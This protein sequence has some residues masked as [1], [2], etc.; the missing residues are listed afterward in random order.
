VTEVVQL[1]VSGLENGISYSLVGLALVLIYQTSAA[2]NFAQGTMAAISGFVA[3]EIVVAN[4]LPWVLGALAGIL[5]GGLLGGV[6][7]R[8]A[9]RPLLGAPLL[10]LVIATI[11]VDS[12]LSNLTQLIR[13]PDTRALPS[14]LGG[15]DLHLGDV[16]INRT[17]LV[18]AASTIAIL[19]GVGWLLRHTRLGLAMR[20]FADDQFASELQG[21]SPQH[22][23]RMVWIISAAIGGIT[24]V[25][26]G[27]LLFIQ[28][29]YMTPIFIK[30]FTAAVLGGF[31][32][33]GGAVAGGLL[34]GVLEA[35]SVKYVSSTFAPILPLLIILVA[36]LARPSGVFNR[37]SV[38]QRV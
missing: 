28:V 9:I 15:S 5:V 30:G 32:S 23:S 38:V 11:A 14:P 27:P 18:I 10:S 20:A 16:A 29:G 2:L 1:V 33:N 25:L 4:H 21:I 22:V 19:L 24:G 36:L 34:L 8:V 13:G 3:Y 12:I 31:V 7:E 26:F 6:T 35:L 37:K 17:Y